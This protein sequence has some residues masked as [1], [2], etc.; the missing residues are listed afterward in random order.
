MSWAVVE[1]V[2][3]RCDLTD[4]RE[5]MVMIALANHANEDGV[6]WPSISKIMELSRM[7]ERGVQQIMRRLSV[8]GYLEIQT[9]GGKGGKNLYRVI[10]NPA[11][12]AGF[13][14]DGIKNS[15]AP[16]AGEG[17]V[18]HPAPGA[19]EVQPTTQN[20]APERSKPRTGCTRT[21]KNQY[22]PFARAAAAGFP[23]VRPGMAET[24]RAGTGTSASEVLEFWAEKIREGG[25][26]SQSALRPDQ[27]RE[28]VA[29]G[30]ATE[31]QV[32]AAGL[33]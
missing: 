28:I 13:A 19:G 17:H 31:A 8:R 16:G 11:P 10:P 32:R 5:V 30:M 14:A 6:C 20:P 22:E 4:P 25:Y 9:R 18:V 23:G 26:V 33:R 1:Q 29:R 12:G 7:S 24:T 3:E 15:P 21:F 27:V 2:L